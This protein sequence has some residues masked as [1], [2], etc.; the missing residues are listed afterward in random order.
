M[1]LKEGEE[2]L[3]N[4]MKAKALMDEIDRNMRKAMRADAQA[5][6]RALRARASRTPNGDMEMA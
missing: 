3:V 5:V 2:R 6:R 1:S 4:D